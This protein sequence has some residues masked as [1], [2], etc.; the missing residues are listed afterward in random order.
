[1]PGATTIRKRK[2]SVS[3]R[4]RGEVRLRSQNKKLLRWLDRWLAT[5]EDHS[6]QWWSEL[7]ADFQRHPVSFRP[8]Q[9]G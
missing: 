6:E 4:R 5:P 2:T 7:E 8:T 1:M 9:A 3:R